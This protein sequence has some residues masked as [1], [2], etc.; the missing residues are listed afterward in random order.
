MATT[1]LDTDYHNDGAFLA[2]DDGIGGDPM[3]NG[4]FPG[5]NV[6]LD[7]TSLRYIS[8]DYF[9]PIPATAWLFGSGLLALLG[10]ARH[11]RR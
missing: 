5:F 11:K 6:S 7:F 8:V 3:D 9:V 10:T 2:G 4:P 1:S